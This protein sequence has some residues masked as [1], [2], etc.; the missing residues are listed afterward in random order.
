MGRLV[1]FSVVD[2]NGAGVGGQTVVAGEASVT[3][4]VSGLG[5]ALLE[6]GSTVITV[7]GVKVY[8]GPVAALKPL[9][10]F[11]TAGKRVD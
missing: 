7:N 11:T 9:E 8:E 1:K 3:T 5:Q 6:D 10:V 4:N 2:G